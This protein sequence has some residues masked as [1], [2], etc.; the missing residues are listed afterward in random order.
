VLENKTVLGTVNS[1]MRDF[2][3]GIIDLLAAEKRW[4]GLLAKFITAKY[5]PEKI[6]EAISSMDEQIKPVIDF[7]TS[8]TGRRSPENL[9]RAQKESVQ[10]RKSV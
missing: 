3:Q 1:H 5:P 4:P 7:E 9:D 2:Q 10:A 6:S 8:D